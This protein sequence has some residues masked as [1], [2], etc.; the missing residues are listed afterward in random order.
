M[1]LASL[2]TFALGCR[3]LSAG[4]AYPAGIL[5]GGGYL[6]SLKN[7]S[8]G[9]PREHNENA[10]HH[11][12]SDHPGARDK[13]KG[14]APSSQEH[15]QRPQPQ[16]MLPGYVPLSMDQVDKDDF[17]DLTLAQW[18]PVENYYPDHGWYG[19]E[20]SSSAGH[21][22]NLDE[23]DG[24]PITYPSQVS[25]AWQS[26]AMMRTHNISNG[27]C[28]RMLSTLINTWAMRTTRTGGN[29]NRLIIRSCG[30]IHRQII[31]MNS[32]HQTLN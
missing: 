30:I 16:T 10:S 9:T 4:L 14:E 5:P 25:N 11:V 31:T 13:G 32:T 8:L 6:P 7:P 18:S 3:Q 27:Q 22:P 29:F 19:M 12:K 15:P 1:K 2:I 17:P 24:L 21:C 20:T 26:P 23:D 28:I